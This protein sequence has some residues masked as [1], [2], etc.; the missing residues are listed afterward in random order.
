[1]LIFFKNPEGLPNLWDFKKQ[2]NDTAR[3]NKRFR[4]KPER[5]AIRNNSVKPRKPLNPYSLKYS[6]FI[7][8]FRNIPEF[9]RRHAEVI[10]EKPVISGAGVKTGIF[11]HSIYRMFSCVYK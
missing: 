3:A 7:F 5:K 2:S 11:A 8:F 1:M 9:C 6:F 4:T 10:A